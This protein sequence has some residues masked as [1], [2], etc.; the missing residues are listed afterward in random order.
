MTTSSEHEHKKVNAAIHVAFSADDSLLSAI[1]H[2]ARCK[3][4]KPTITWSQHLAPAYFDATAYSLADSLIHHPFWRAYFLDQISF[5]HLC[6]HFS[7]ATVSPGKS[8]FSES[9]A[10][11]P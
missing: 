9:T 8:M 10:Q 7:L 11:K 3:V 6:E 1:F 2:I 4:M 5:S